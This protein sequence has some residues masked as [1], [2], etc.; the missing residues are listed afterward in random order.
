[1][2]QLYQV[3]DQWGSPRTVAWGESTGL[4]YYAKARQRLDEPVHPLD[5][6][7]D[8]KVLGLLRACRSARD[9]L[10]VLLMARAG[11]RRGEAVD[12]RRVPSR[13]QRWTA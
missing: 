2:A 10:I 1:M 5:R 11:L 12:L 9:R 8:A 13:R 7:T 6:A 3:A 4:R